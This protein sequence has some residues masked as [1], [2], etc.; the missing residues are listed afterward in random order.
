MAR[1][2]RLRLVG[3]RSGEP[4]EADNGLPHPQY[5]RVRYEMETVVWRGRDPSLYVIGIHGYIIA[6]MNNDEEVVAGQ[7]QADWVRL[8]Q[9][10]NDGGPPA[11]E[12]FDSIDQELC[13]VFEALYDL[14][15]NEISE[16][17][18]EMGHRDLLYVREIEIL[19]LH[20]GRALGLYVLRNVMDTFGEECAATALCPWPYDYAD[21]P[22]RAEEMGA[23]GF[24]KDRVVATKK[25]TDYVSRLGF[26]RVRDTEFFAVDM[27]RKLPQID[28]LLDRRYR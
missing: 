4:I 10:T 25:L 2:S 18:A 3:G 27:T 1:I 5:Y 26:S 19:P 13:N 22:K 28:D 23:G 15:T 16:D 24:V 8:G 21:E 20:R 12:I 7:V 6:P 9:A 14:E 11:F 17:V